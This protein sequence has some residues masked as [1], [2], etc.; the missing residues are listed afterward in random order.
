MKT[1]LYIRGNPG[2]GKITLARLISEQM[3]WRLFWFHDLKNAVSDI[4]QERRISRLMDAVTIPVLEYLLEKGD[5]IIYAR[6]SPDKES[7]EGILAAVASYPAYRF[8]V[9]RLVAEYETLHSRVINREDPYR[10]NTKEALDEYLAEKSV[11]DITGEHIIATDG[12]TPEEVA[13][14][15]LAIIS[16]GRD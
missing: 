15:V 9:V 14:K 12:L 5:D 8:C 16:E 3:G 2:T 4:V 7:V 6:P 13:L 1:F 10:I 11:M